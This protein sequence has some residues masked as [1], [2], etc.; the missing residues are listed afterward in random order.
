MPGN[1]FGR[2]LQLRCRT[3]GHSL[4]YTA[5]KRRMEV[6]TWVCR[7]IEDTNGIHLIPGISLHVYHED[8]TLSPDEMMFFSYCENLELNTLYF[9]RFRANET[10]RLY[11]G[12]EALPDDYRDIAERA[13]EPFYRQI[14]DELWVE[15]LSALHVLGFSGT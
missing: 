1:I 4:A 7:I 12:I 9:P 10:Q 11:Q 15:M 13:S 8:R 14:V 2:W 6:G 3:Y 5:S